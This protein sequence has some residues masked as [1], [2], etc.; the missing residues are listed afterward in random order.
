MP[1]RLLIGTAGWSVPRQSAPH[2]PAEGTHL[3]RYGQILPAVEINSSFYRPHAAAT[4]ARWAGSVHPGFRFSVKVPRSITHEQRLRQPRL[5]NPLIDKFLA[6]TAGLGATLG[7]LLVQLP[8]SLVFD[9]RIAGRFFSDLRSRYSGPVVCEPRHVTWFSAKSDALLVRHRVARVAADPAPA[10]GAGTPGAWP[11]I[12]YY[13][14][15]GSPR[16]YWSSYSDEYLAALA[17]VVCRIPA[18]VDVWIIFDNTASGAAAE[19]AWALH[20][21]ICLH[22]DGHCGQQRVLPRDQRSDGCLRPDAALGS[23]LAI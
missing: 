12:V 13:R 22:A 17:D 11:G 4:Y 5:V 21:T 9:A 8:P 16:M 1:A 23:G 15:H 20:M 10:P 3:H 6:E 2:F 18:A 7:P 19:N 14:L